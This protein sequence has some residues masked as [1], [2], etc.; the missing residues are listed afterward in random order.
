MIL[1]SPATI[2]NVNASRKRLQKEITDEGQLF[3]C[4]NFRVTRDM[5]LD[6]SRS[7]KLSMLTACKTAIRGRVSCVRNQF[8]PMICA[9]CPASTE[10]DNV[11]FSYAS[12]IGCLLYLRLT[13]PDILVTIIILTR[14][15]KNPQHKHWE[16]VTDV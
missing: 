4:L 15:M 16:T 2:L 13:H 8:F 6:N 12:A 14:F 11:T 7:T 9:M 10:K 5:Q 3:W 1:S